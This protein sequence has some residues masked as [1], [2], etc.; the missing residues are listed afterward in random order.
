MIAG[1]DIRGTNMLLRRMTEHVK[2]QN[3]FA[4]AIDVLIVVMGGIGIQV[5]NWTPSMSCSSTSVAPL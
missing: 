3:W 1:C 5:A 2:E 4:V